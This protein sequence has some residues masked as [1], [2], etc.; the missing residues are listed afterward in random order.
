MSWQPGQSGNPKGRPP[1][2]KKTIRAALREQLNRD[3]F[4]RVLIA[5]A[6][7]GDGRAMD[8]LLKYHDGLPAQMA[9][10]EGQVLPAPV[11]FMPSNGREFQGSDEDGN[12]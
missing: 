9:P 2:G 1:L 4:A 8:L 12:E 7:E 10:D 6:M 11:V 5:R 3:D